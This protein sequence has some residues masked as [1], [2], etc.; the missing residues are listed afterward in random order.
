VLPSETGFRTGLLI[1]GGVALVAAATALAIPAR[2]R[3]ASSEPEPE[4]AGQVEA[5]V[6]A[7]A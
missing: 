3:G 4:F 1:G 6:A 5:S 7:T 2:R